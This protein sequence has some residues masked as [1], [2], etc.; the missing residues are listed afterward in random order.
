MSQESSLTGPHPAQ[1]RKQRVHAWDLFDEAARFAASNEEILSD[2]YATFQ[3]MERGLRLVY[4]LDFK[5]RTYPHC[6]DHEMAKISETPMPLSGKK[7]P[8]NAPL[9]AS[10]TI[11]SDADVRDCRT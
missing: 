1:E 11:D 9:Q 3:R 6:Q 10:G 7:G 5:R 8:Q 4:G 2:V